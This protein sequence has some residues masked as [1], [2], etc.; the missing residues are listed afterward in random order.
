MYEILNKK[1]TSAKNKMEEEVCGE[2]AD[3]TPKI[4]E[5]HLKVAEKAVVEAKNL[6]PK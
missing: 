4:F 1:F 2:K 6:M 3:W 5:K